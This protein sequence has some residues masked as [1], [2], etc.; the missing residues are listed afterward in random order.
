MKGPAYV[1][2]VVSQKDLLAGRFERVDRLFVR[3]DDVDAELKPA[4]LYAVTYHKGP[5]ESVL[6]IYEPFLRQLE[7]QGL[8]VCGDAYE[9]YLL[10]KLSVQDQTD[11]I[12][13]IS[14]AVHK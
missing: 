2:S 5:Y 3:M 11:F 13:K 6:E 12:F 8:A 1:G 7:E 4:G 10:G 14:L 9:E